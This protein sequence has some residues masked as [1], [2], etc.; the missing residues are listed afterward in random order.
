MLLGKDSGN[1][2]RN[3]CSSSCSSDQIPFA[4][5]SFLQALTVLNS[6]PH[7]KKK[8]AEN[9]MNRALSSIMEK[10]RTKGRIMQ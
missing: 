5:L 8:A 2:G 10:I 4:L 6:D 7:L 3:P 1:S 9:S